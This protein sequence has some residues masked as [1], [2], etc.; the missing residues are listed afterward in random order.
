[1]RRRVTVGPLKSPFERIAAASLRA[2]WTE[3]VRQ[4]G[5]ERNREE[6]SQRRLMRG[7]G[8][9]LRLGVGVIVLRLDVP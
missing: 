4:I 7:T 9:N 2:R 8:E 1:M 3:G 5:V 6:W